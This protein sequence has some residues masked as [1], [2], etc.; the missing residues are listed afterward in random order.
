MIVNSCLRVLIPSQFLYI[1]L[2]SFCLALSSPRKRY[3]RSLTINYSRLFFVRAVS[4]VKVVWPGVFKFSFSYNS[5]FCITSLLWSSQIASQRLGEEVLS[6]K[7]W[8]WT[9][10]ITNSA[11]ILKT[12]LFS[13]FLHCTELENKEKEEDFMAT[14]WTSVAMPTGT[15]LLGHLINL[16]CQKVVFALKPITPFFLI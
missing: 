2:L 1:Q 6:P 13:L 5:L 9:R 14:K 12:S 8:N 10:D 15:E 3:G 11:G 7:M 4:Q 16:L